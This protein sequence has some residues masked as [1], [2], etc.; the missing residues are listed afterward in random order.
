M[1]LH[2][3]MCVCMCICVCVGMAMFVGNRSEKSEGLSFLA[4]M[5]LIGGPYTLNMWNRKHLRYWGSGDRSK[6]DKKS[7]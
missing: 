6:F 1:P 2:A 4:E 3:L 7:F 5:D